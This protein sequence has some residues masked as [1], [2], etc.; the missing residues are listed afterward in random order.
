VL[1]AIEYGLPRGGL[2]SRARYQEINPPGSSLPGPG[3]VWSLGV[4]QFGVWGLTRVGP[5]RNSPDKGSGVRVAPP[6]PLS[7][8]SW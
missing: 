6:S 1:R 2:P 3:L 5:V 7:M 8:C 4:D